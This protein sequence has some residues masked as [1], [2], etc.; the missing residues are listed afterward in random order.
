MKT[1]K[2]GYDPSAE[3]DLEDLYRWIATE[4]GILVADG[5]LDRITGFCERLAHFPNRGMKR[6]DL[7]PGLRTLGFE[8]RAVIAFRVLED[9]VRIVRVLYG[10]R[11][12]DG[13]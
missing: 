12:F 10:G 11:E 4:A 8:R 5:Y 13:V 3:V 2:I 6:D 1:W 9:E 7:A